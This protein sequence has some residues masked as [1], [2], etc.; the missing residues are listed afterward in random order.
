MPSTTTLHIDLPDEIARELQASVSRGDYASVP[1]AI[2]DALQGWR[3][4][5]LIRAGMESGPDID[6]DQVFAKLRASLPA[7]PGE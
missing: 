2:R 7:T 3:L 4:R 5:Q 6:A 1:D